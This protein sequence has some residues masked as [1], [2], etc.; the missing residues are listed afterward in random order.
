MGFLK[1]VSISTKV[2]GGFGIVLFLLLVVGSVGGIGIT[3]AV[4]DFDRYRLIAKKTNAAGRVEAHLL[5]AELAVKGFIIDPTEEYLSKAEYEIAKTH[6]LIKVLKELVDPELAETIEAAD[7]QITR[8]DEAFHEVIS[9]Q[10][11]SEKQVTEA[12]GV[13]GPQIE[14]DL[15]EIMEGAYS[16]GNTSVAFRTAGV[17]RALL[18][19]RLY[20]NKFL[21]SN[22]EASFNRAMQESVNVSEA[23]GVLSRG[24]QN[25]DHRKLLTSATT[26]HKEY[27]EVFGQVAESITQRNAIITNTLDTIGPAVVKTMDDTILMLKGEQDR[28]GPEATEHMESARAIEF[29]TT[30]FAVVFGL[31]AAWLIGTGI[32]RPIKSIT[33]SMDSIAS[34]DLGAEVPGLDHGDEIGKM[35]AAVEVFKNNA[36]E[37]KR[38]EQVQIEKDKLAAQEQRQA[39]EKMA[40]EFDTNVGSVVNFVSSAATQMQASAETLNNTAVNAS[41]GVTAV[42]TTTRQTS[43]TVQNIASATE[44]LSSSINEIRRQVSSSSDMADR[45][46]N[47][48]AQ[49]TEQVQGL[50]ETSN[51]IGAVIDM[52]RDIAEQTNLL[53]LNATIEAARAGDSGKGF[54]VVANEVKTLAAQTAKAT[55]DISS[56]VQNVQFETQKA[57]ESIELIA[58]TIREINEVGTSIS[59]AIEEQHAATQEIAGNIEQTAAGASEVS[60]NINS[61]SEQVGETG[62]SANEVLGASK[63]LALQAEKMSGLV[64]SFLLNVR[65]AA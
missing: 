9:L 42:A 38:L 5:E 8:Y 31:I 33:N 59:S 45:A 53:A 34:G 6:K 26:L 7:S 24:L 50:V 54:A 39:V 3:Q 52:I 2:F 64:S 28:I 30:L 47:Q 55:E 43:E 23:I 61:V 57:A 14:R 13:L 15:V 11:E 41:N 17:V 58:N 65:S 29:G 10:A 63:E 4:N 18:L 19:E 1:N 27:V 49:T 60:N 46:V 40:D 25:P 51:R 35:A 44:E 37:V 20:A 32:A 16:D 21:A 48:A 22:D 62:N 12:L 36:V 56:Q